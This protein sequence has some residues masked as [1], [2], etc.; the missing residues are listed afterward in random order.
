VHAAGQQQAG[1]GEEV[2]GCRHQPVGTAA[3]RTVR[4]RNIAETQLVTTPQASSTNSWATA[5]GVGEVH[6]CL[7]SRTMARP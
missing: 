4:L 3:D 1:E 7:V 6:I 2:V 5:G